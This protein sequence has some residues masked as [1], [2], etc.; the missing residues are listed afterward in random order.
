MLIE[1]LEKI[2]RERLSDD[3]FYHSQCVM[4]RCEELAKIYNVDIEKAKKV[5]IVHDIAK[6]MNE[7][8]KLKYVQEQNMIIDEVEKENTG[9]LHAKIGANIAKKQF[10]FTEDMVEAVAY[11]TTAKANMGLLAKILFVADATG[12][13]RKWEDLEYAR[14]RSETNLDD[15]I[16]Y[17]I[18]LNI[19]K[20][21]E[22]KK[23]I[24]PDSILARNYLMKLSNNF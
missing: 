4:K 11:H 22:R 19:Q 2:A 24:H 6:E 15:V 23:L 9:L 13:D 21:I 3:R 10:D 16:I 5:G 20:N 18:E 1:E 17:I 7:E 8:E 14:K 12:E